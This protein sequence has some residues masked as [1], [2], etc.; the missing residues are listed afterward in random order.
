M[1]EHWLP[2]MVLV[3]KKCEELMTVQQRKAGR[4]EIRIEILLKR[5][6]AMK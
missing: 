5:T 1:I 4:R 6:E 3:L 2:S